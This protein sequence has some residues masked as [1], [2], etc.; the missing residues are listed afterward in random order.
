MPE[1]RPGTP[2]GPWTITRHL[3]SGGNATVWAATRGSD[4]GEVALKVLNT[5]NADREPYKRFAKEITFLHGLQDTTGI[6]PLVDAYLPDRPTKQDR[7]WL[8][9]PVATG[10]ADALAGAP[11]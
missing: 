2:L 3:G 5:L 4:G 9:M 6:L 7:P 1:L 10:L 11:L 8:A